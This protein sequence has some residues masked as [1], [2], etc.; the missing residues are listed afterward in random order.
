VSNGTAAI[1]N[2][3][4]TMFSVKGGT[5]LQS[6]GTTN[7]T[8][9]FATTFTV[10]DISEK[11]NIRIIARVS[12][13]GYSDGSDYQ[14]LEVLP[15]LSIQI[16][17]NPDTVKSEGTA[18]ISIY[19]KSDEDDVANAS[20]IVSSTGGSLSSET[21][22]T[23]LDGMFSLA[24]IAPQ[25]TSF[26]NINITAVA[27][28]EG[29][30]NGVGQTIVGVDPKTLDVQISADSSVTFSEAKMNVTV[31]V[32]YDATPIIEANVTITAEMGTFVI[33][34]ALTNTEGYARFDFSA[35]TVNEQK[36][37]ILTAHATKTR[38]AEGQGQLGITVN[39]RTFNITIGTLTVQ[40][41]ESA[42]VLVH[43]KCKEDGTPV[44]GATVTI[45]SREGNFTAVTKPTDDAGMCT[46]VFNAPQTTAQ[47]YVV[48]TVN[49]T[50]DGYL[51]GG[52]ETSIIVTPRTVP[53]SEEGGWPILTILL[54]LIPIIIV[55]IVVI[56]IKMKIIVVSAGEQEQE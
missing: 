30:M 8:G 22:T 12:R 50:K 37:I 47:I 14:Y 55:V 34:T 43:V 1:E 26:L 52:N 51:D 36:Y 31:I 41:G 56:L 29:Y 44:A 33:T 39:P 3:T 27:M 7:N 10:Q 32:R 21:G 2:A 5:F 19:V 17:A 13:S 38:Y 54:I 48:T 40:S 42:N 23:N 46:F 15:F 53:Q 4:V 28:K 35:P 16:V 6:S 9:Y 18:Q 45:S 49:A 24:F 20:V 25:T 11:A